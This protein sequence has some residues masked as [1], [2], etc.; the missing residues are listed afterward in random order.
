MDP[1][2]NRNAVHRVGGPFHRSGAFANYSPRSVP[3]FPCGVQTAG[4]SKGPSQT[5]VIDLYEN[6][7]NYAE[8]FI[9]K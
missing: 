4:S 8:D 1:I 9:S 3:A 6:S 7:Y 5:R 2:K